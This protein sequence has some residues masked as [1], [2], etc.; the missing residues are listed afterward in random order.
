MIVS[1]LRRAPRRPLTLGTMLGRISR[2]TLRHEPYARQLAGDTIAFSALA[3]LAMV[4]VAQ[5]AI[6]AGWHLSS[7]GGAR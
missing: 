3:M 4:V 1:G 5:I 7:V 6:R 2:W